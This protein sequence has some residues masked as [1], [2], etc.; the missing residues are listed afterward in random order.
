MNTEQSEDW[1]KQVWRQELKK[2]EDEERVL[3][4]EEVRKKEDVRHARNEKFIHEVINNRD[5]GQMSIYHKAL[6]RYECKTYCLMKIAKHYLKNGINERI[7]IVDRSSAMSGRKMRELAKELDILDE[8]DICEESD[9]SHMTM[10]YGTNRLYCMPLTNV[11]VYI[12]QGSTIILMD[13]ITRSIPESLVPV[14]FNRG[15]ITVIMTSP[16]MRK[17]ELFEN[18]K[19]V[20]W[21]VAFAPI[22]HYTKDQQQILK[23]YMNYDMSKK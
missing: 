17:E 3:W 12:A 1:E 9:Y 21:F 11:N 7:C 20:H 15:T 18:M 13:D 16:M 8:E 10:R 23:V 5:S 19:N 14:I 2:R 22:P 6:M 4:K